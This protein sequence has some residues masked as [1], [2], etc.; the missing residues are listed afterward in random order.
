M[1]ASTA[2]EIE[3]EI[4]E[5]PECDEF[6]FR[7]H[8]EQVV[9]RMKLSDEEKE[10]YRGV[11]QKLD[12][13]RPCVVETST[14]VQVFSAT[15]AAGYEGVG[16]EDE[17][18]EGGVEVLDASAAALA[19]DPKPCRLAVFSAEVDDEEGA[20]G[21]E[22][23]EDVPVR[24]DASAI[25]TPGGYRVP[26]ELL[27][28]LH[29]HQRSAL[30]DLLLVRMANDEGAMLAHSM[31]TGK[32][33]TALAL[34]SVY[35]S[36]HA[37]KGCAVVVMPR[38]L[39]LQWEGEI[40]RFDALQ[41]EAFPVLS[42]SELARVHKRWTKTARG[43]LLIGTELFRKD[44]ASLSI[45][46]ET[47]V[48]VDEA[49]LQLKTGS[50]Q[51]FAVVDNLPTRRRVLLSGTPMQNRLR[52]Y[53][54][55]VSLISPGLIGNT[56]LEFETSYARVIEAGAQKGADEQAQFDG[57]KTMQMLRWDIESVVDFASAEVIAEQL[58]EKREFVVMH[59]YR[60]DDEE[61]DTEGNY[62]ELRNT[63]H[64]KGL[65]VKAV[66]VG[67]LLN[68]IHAEGNERTIVFS[69]RIDTLKHLQ[70]Q[71]PGELLIGE[72]KDLD[73]R[74]RVLDAFRETDKAVL[75]V[76]M[77]VG[78]VGLNLN[79]ATRVILVDISWNPMDD[80]QAV[81]RAH[82][83]GQTK[84]VTTY[85]LV[86]SEALEATAYWLGVR[87][88]RLASTI[89][90]DQDVARVYE[91]E[92]LEG[93]ISDHDYSVYCSV[94]DSLKAE[95][96]VLAQT[97]D[98]LGDLVVSILD[99]DVNV[100]TNDFSETPYEKRAFQNERNRRAMLKADRVIETDEG[101][102]TVSVT[103]FEVEGGALVA[104]MVPVTVDRQCN[105]ASVRFVPNDYVWLALMP[106]VDDPASEPMM[107]VAVAKLADAEDDPMLLE[108]DDWNALSQTISTTKKTGDPYKNVDIG[109]FDE[110][111][112]AFK[113][114]LVGNDGEVGPWSSPSTAV[115]VEDEVV[116]D[117]RLDE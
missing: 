25:E 110:G 80:K 65:E 40:D 53:Y 51:L 101:E 43:V 39:L 111:V 49:H 82:R 74:Q 20:S 92:D 98:T 115:V 63:E 85:R 18:E 52:E 104:P 7:A 13:E 44:H 90:D 106:A 112:Y 38:T 84:M 107:E 88:A 81:A 5:H 86:A 2:D 17:D 37:H 28:M 117:E 9:K 32:T 10:F 29:A 60:F 26:M 34:I 93:V 35:A 100:S 103:T 83:L 75:Y 67:E 116:E 61:A 109:K 79:C 1:W 76:G 50:T 108:D 72:V 12:Q 62:L 78:G 6:D 55:M 54:N 87:K 69:Q 64:E 114:R 102:Q 47:L 14:G 22:D 56:A 91:S 41:L 3:T 42:A 23:D 31:G 27:A 19:N 11:T 77:Q 4:A 16:E 33:L 96:P 36:K 99:H 113:A 8:N 95:D 68:A 57:K 71:H 66:V 70:K 45:S 94:S 105:I 59:K 24:Y 89:T 46:S 15:G 30:L 97:C 48:I 58:P 73:A 21:M